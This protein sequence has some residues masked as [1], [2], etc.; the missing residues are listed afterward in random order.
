M[1]QAHEVNIPR[2]KWHTPEWWIVTRPD[3]TTFTTFTSKEF[4]AEYYG[5]AGWPY[6]REQGEHRSLY[7]DK[8][9]HS[10]AKGR[11]DMTTGEMRTESY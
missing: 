7:A 10:D 5:K 6:E 2:I 11:I 3:G 1:L 8:R 4:M 9:V